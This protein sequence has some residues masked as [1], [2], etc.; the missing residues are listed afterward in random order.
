MKPVTTDSLHNSVQARPL[1]SPRHAHHVLL[2][3]DA[4]F[5]DSAILAGG[6]V[7]GVEGTRQTDIGK[8]ILAHARGVELPMMHRVLGIGGTT[9]DVV[10]DDGGRSSGDWSVGDGDTGLDDA[11]GREVGHDEIELG[12][13]KM[14][15]QLDSRG[16]KAGK[17]AGRGSD[18][19]ERWRRKCV[20][21]IYL[22]ECGVITCLY[23]GGRIDTC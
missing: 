12:V 3:L 23:D 6:R 4:N 1:M 20:G 2:I 22:C 14:V 15:V 21:S 8:I 17:E 16:L 7:P 19:K 5:L 9:I 18:E 10:L 13:V 11:D